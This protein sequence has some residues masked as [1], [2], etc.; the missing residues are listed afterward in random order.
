MARASRS[1]ASAPEPIPNCFTCQWRARTEW[2]VLA[3]DDVALLNAR[4]VTSTFGAGQSI[5]RQ[6][7][8]CR[9]VY[10]LL[11]GAVAIRKIDAQGHAV[12]VRMRYAGETMGYRDHFAGGVFTTSAETLEPTQ[13][14]FIDAEAVRDFLERNPALGLHFLQRVSHDL[15]HAEQNLLMSAALTA[16]TRLAHLLLTLKDRYAEA[17]RNGSL[18]MRLPLSRQDVADMVGSRPETITRII[19]AF[20]QD[21]VALFSGRTVVIPDLDLLLDEIDPPLKR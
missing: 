1:R 17:K 9:G 7:E 8:P 5:F 15:Q 21:G 10:I 18:V 2:C 13:V 19:Q 3:D 6:G 11:S 4:K 12:M 14:C 20:E 16:R